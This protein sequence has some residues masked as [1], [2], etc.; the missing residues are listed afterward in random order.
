MAWSSSFAIP[1]SNQVYEGANGV[2][3]MD[4][5]G[6]KLGPQGRRRADGAV[7]ASDGWIAEQEKDEAMKPFVTG[8]KRGTET[9]QAADHVAW[10]PMA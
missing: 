4:L 9:L 10:R 1:A 2:Q 5:V 3:A 7:R 6:R 8:V